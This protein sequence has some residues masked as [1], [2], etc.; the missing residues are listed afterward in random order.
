MLEVLGAFSLTGGVCYVTWRWLLRPCRDWLDY[1]E[2]LTDL[3]VEIERIR[4]TD[5]GSDGDRV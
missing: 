1:R 3:R 5:G 4:T 2:K